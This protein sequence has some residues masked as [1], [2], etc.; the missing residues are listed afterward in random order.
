MRVAIF[1]AEDTY[2]YMQYIHHT[3]MIPT[4]HSDKILAHF[5]VG[6]LR[7]SGVTMTTMTTIDIVH[8]SIV[9]FIVGSLCYCKYHCC[10]C[11]LNGSIGLNFGITVYYLY[12]DYC[13][14]LS[15]V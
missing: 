7:I 10:Y 13:C 2:T 9:M 3:D 4:P 6:H 1:L 11:T 15:I 5:Q 14:H 8:C 12:C